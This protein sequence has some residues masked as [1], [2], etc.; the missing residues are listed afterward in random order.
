MPRASTASWALQFI[1]ARGRKL[2]SN[3]SIKQNYP[4]TIYPR[5]GTETLYAFGTNPPLRHYNLSPQGDGNFCSHT[6]HFL[7]FLLQFIPARGR[8]R[9]SVQPMIKYLLLQFIPARGRKRFVLCT[10]C[11]RW[12]YNLSPQGDGNM[13]V[14]CVLRHFSITIYPRKGTETQR[15]LLTCQRS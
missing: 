7:Y 11:L 8:K 6:V 9:F 12:D 1:P 2:R 10:F 15:R 4:I 5:K 14:L 3:P 13:G